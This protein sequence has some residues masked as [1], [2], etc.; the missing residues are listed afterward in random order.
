[1]ADVSRVGWLLAGRYRLLAEV[2]K[3]GMGRVWKAHDEVLR[4]DVAVKEVK[5]E[6]L[7]QAE[8]ETLLSRTLN[9]ARLTARL[10]HPHIAAVHDVVVADER[11][12]IILQL[13]SAPTLAHILATQGPLPVT[14]AARVGLQLL[15]ALQTAH[16]GGVVHRDVKPANILLKD[17]DHA[18]LTD[19]G[20]AAGMGEAQCLTQTGMVVGT[21]AYIAPERV[22]G[23]PPTPQAD[24][25]SLGITLYLAVEGRPPFKSSNALAT[26]NAVLTAQPAP[27]QH[28][29]PLA[30]LITGL[31]AK[32]PDERIDADGARRLLQRALA[33]AGDQVPSTGVIMLNA[34]TKPRAPGQRK[35]P[36]GGPPGKGGQLRL[37]SRGRHVATVTALVIAGVVTSVWPQ[38]APS[39][40]NPGPPPD[41]SA[42]VPVPQ[43]TPP[44]A[45]EMRVVERA[46]PTRSPAGGENSSDRSPAGQET[47]VVTTTGN[48]GGKAASQGRQ[49]QPR[50]HGKDRHQ[51]NG[52][53]AR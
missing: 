26:I 32:D 44:L 20:L 46:E 35:R 47:T 13:V 31:L 24:L 50:G 52:R 19:F 38:P 3:G 16:A 15:D 22:A 7:A 49:Q 18:V 11:P 39:R 17:G 5:L 9:E 1:M 43:A 27:F 53:G 2:G 8:R 12:W 6:R 42:I 30:P 41:I 51:G 23:A 4:R 29:G 37:T 33:T 25:W 34:E 10:S 48:R 14:T 36:V 45:L 40:S 21:P 28:A